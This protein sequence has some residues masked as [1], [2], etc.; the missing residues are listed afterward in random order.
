MKQLKLVTL[1]EK[2]PD[3]GRWRRRAG[4]ISFFSQA[5]VLR[6]GR[7]AWEMSQA[8]LFAEELNGFVCQDAA[9]DFDREERLLGRDVGAGD[10]DLIHPR[11]DLLDRGSKDQ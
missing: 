11:G 6:S 2:H 10:H 1:Y 8:F 7:R 4:A 3:R 5:P 9:R